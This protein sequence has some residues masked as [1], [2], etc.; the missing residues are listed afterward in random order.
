MDRRKLKLTKDLCYGDFVKKGENGWWVHAFLEEESEGILLEKG[1]VPLRVIR[2]KAKVIEKPKEYLSGWD[3][4]LI[5][6]GLAG[7]VVLVAL[8]LSFR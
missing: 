8:G 5:I 2:K 6:F 1:V 7:T 4:L 3:L